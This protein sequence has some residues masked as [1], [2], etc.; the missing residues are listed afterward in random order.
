MN[1]CYPVT[2]PHGILKSSHTGKQWWRCFR[3][4]PLG[5]TWHVWVLFRLK[6]LRSCVW[7]CIICDLG[8][9]LCLGSRLK[10]Y[11]IVMSGLIHFLAV[12]FLFSMIKLTCLSIPFWP[13][14]LCLTPCCSLIIPIFIHQNLPVLSSIL[15]VP[16]PAS[17]SLVG[18]G[19]I[20]LRKEWGFW[21]LA[22]L[23][24]NP[25]STTY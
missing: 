3:M 9:V 13:T 12:S 15:S 24:L 18:F 1:L 16:L 4:L 19:N 17:S 23:S 25:G 11:W 7:T 2:S 20:L 10:L 21:S 6:Y 5:Q 8:P 22:Y 14:S